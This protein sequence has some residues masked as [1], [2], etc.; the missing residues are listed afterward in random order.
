MAANLGVYRYNWAIKEAVVKR[1]Y[2]DNHDQL[3]SHL[4]DVIGVYNYLAASKPSKA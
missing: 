3:R 2:Y 4:R 1:Y